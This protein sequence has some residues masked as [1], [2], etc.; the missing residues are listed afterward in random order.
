MDAKERARRQRIADLVNAQGGLE[1]WEEDGTLHTI[2]PWDEETGD[3]DPWGAA[4][5]MLLLY[6]DPE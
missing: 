6:G 1:L 5:L 3:P 4:A 2:V